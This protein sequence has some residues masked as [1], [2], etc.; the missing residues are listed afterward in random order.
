MC[1]TLQHTRLW[2]QGSTM[3]SVAQ[4][5]TSAFQAIGSSHSYTLSIHLTSNSCILYKLCQN[6]NQTFQLAYLALHRTI[7]HS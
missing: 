7:Q 4:I 6:E 1:S 2:S 5:W 3:D